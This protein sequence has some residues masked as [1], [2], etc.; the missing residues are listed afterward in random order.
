VR[1]TPGG[2]RKG[3]AGFDVCFIH[4]KGDPGHPVGGEG[5]LIELVQAPPEVVQAHRAARD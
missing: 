5:V 1:F 3:A 2:I 4:P